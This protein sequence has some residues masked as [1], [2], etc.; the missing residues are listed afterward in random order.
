MNSS[1]RN[2]MAK[3]AFAAACGARVQ[4]AVKADYVSNHDYKAMADEA[5]AAACGAR[6]PKEK[7]E[8]INGKCPGSGR[9]INLN[10]EAGRVQMSAIRAHESR[11]TLCPVCGRRIGVIK[12]P[13][14]LFFYYVAT[15]KM[16]NA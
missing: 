2:E 15:H 1:E 16:G 5:W 14:S 8:Q 13:G 10:T 4:A 7:P 11:K 12:N 3:V 9:E 6:A